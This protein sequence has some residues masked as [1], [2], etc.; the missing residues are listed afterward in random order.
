MLKAALQLMELRADQ[1]SQDRLAEISK[2]IVASSAPPR[3]K[4]QADF[5]LTRGAVVA[6]AAGNQA[7]EADKQIQAFAQRY[8]DAQDKPMAMAYAVLLAHGSGRTALRDQILRQLE[9]GHYPQ[10][11]VRI[12][13][14]RFHRHPELG[15]PFIAELTRLD[16]TKL[17]LPQD[18]S[19]KVVVVD[20]WATWCPPCVAAAPKMVELYAK[21]QPQGVEFVGVS[22]DPAEARGTLENFITQ[23]GMTWIQTFSGL[24][25]SDPTATQYGVESIPSV[26]VIGRDGNVNTDDA[27]AD[28]EAAIRKAM[29]APATVQ[30]ASAPS[31]QGAP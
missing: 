28:P 30:P 2:K 18:L 5:L 12:V 21:Y 11:A 3:E 19:G 13:L 24:G 9:E 7:E 22:L 31:S 20:F 8:P 15:K 17:K 23:H 25:P 4:L 14:R 6:A 27:G 1:A 16:G 10:E 26:W 29:E